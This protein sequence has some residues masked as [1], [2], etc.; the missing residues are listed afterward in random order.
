MSSKRKFYR[1]IIQIEI[2]SDEPYEGDTLDM[3]QYDITEGHCSGQISDV[4]RN[5][6]QDGKA[7]AKLLEEQRSD[8]EFFQL[9]SDGND[10]DEE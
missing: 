7:M 3:V 9:D 10:L 2:L 5:E 8:P 6:E 4:V 1:T